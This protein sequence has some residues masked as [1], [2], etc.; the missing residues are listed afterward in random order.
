[1]AIEKMKLVKISGSLT[2]LY[3]LSARLCESE[4][5][6][7]DS[8]A[9]YISSSMGFVPFVDDNPYAGELSEL[10][11]IAKAAKF[12]RELKSIEESDSDVD[13]KDA[14]YLKDVEKKVI[15]ARCSTKRRYARAVLKNIR[16][17]RALVL[18]LTRYRNANSSKY[19]SVICRRRATK[20]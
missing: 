4:C 8:A 13:E 1:M 15:G 7:P 12:D 20:S 10:R 14:S 16:T 19:A 18:T 17:L 2:K 6:H 5:F 11:D 9:K 3:D